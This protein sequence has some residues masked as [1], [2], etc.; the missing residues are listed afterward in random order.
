MRHTL[1]QLLTLFVLLIGLSIPAPARSA[2][3]APLPVTVHPSGEAVLSAAYPNPFHTRTTF[4]LRVPH[5]QRVAVGIYNVL[6][7]RVRLLYEGIVK[8]GTPSRFTLTARALPSG[9]YF[10]RAAGE[11]FAKTR[12]VALVR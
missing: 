4:T 7:Q 1:R 9:L 8:A 5:T 12:R 3:P 2:S 11:T 6:G 10:Y